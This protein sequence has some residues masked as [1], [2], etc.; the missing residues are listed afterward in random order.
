VIAA[1]LLL[2]TAGQDPVTAYQDCVEHGFRHPEEEGL[3]FDDKLE[4]AKGGCGNLRPA[5]IA[6]MRKARGSHFDANWSDSEAQ[7]LLDSAV[8]RRLSQAPRPHGAD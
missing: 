5:A 2:A 6:S 8:R 7:V 4:M 1:L 3:E